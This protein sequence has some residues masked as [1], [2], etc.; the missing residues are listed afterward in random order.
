MDVDDPRLIVT[1][2][3]VSPTA[4]RAWNRPQNQYFLHGGVAGG[5]D[6]IV[7]VAAG[8][9]A[10]GAVFG[11]VDGSWGVGYKE[12]G[13]FVAV[14]FTAVA[15]GRLGLREGD[16]EVVFGGGVNVCV[17]VWWFAFVGIKMVGLF[18]RCVGTEGLDRCFD[19]YYTL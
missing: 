4:E 3:A 17:E 11:E 18:G 19:T 12:R 14:G 8:V 15:F 7:G 1:L 16:F 5:E 9:D 2:E 10:V 6:E 13:V